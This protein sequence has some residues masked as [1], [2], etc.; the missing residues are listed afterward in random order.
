MKCLKV[1]VCAL[2]VLSCYK[3]ALAG[4]CHEGEGYPRADHI[5]CDD[6]DQYCLGGADW[7]GGPNIWGVPEWYG[8]SSYPSKCPT[9]GSA[10]N[11]HPNYV[12]LRS[13][14]PKFQDCGGDVEAPAQP[15]SG[16]RA[17]TPPMVVHVVN[18]WADGTET[19][20]AQFSHPFTYR[21]QAA[22]PD[23]NALNGTDANPLILRFH[24]DDDAG[25]SVLYSNSYIELSL[26]E[27]STTGARDNRAPTDYVWYTCPGTSH[28]YGPYPIIC[29]QNR[30]W[31]PG[32][33]AICGDLNPG[34]FNS[35]AIGHLPMMDDNPCHEDEVP[36]VNHFPTQDHWVVFD[37][38]QWT[39]IRSNRFHGLTVDPQTD[40]PTPI[41]KRLQC[42]ESAGCNNFLTVGG[43][44]NVH[45]KITTN[46]ILLYITNG[47][48]GSPWGACIPRQYHG[49]FDTIS[50]GVAPGCEL[51]P[52]TGECIGS[53]DCIQYGRPGQ[54]AYR[55]T[56]YDQ[57]S[58]LGGELYFDDSADPVQ[59]CCHTAYDHLLAGQCE[60][61]VSSECEDPGDIWDPVNDFC[62]DI[63][64]CVDPFADADHD[65][66]VDQ[67]DFGI[68]QACFS[69][70]GNDYE[71]GCKCF[72]RDED[73]DVDGDD[74]SRTGDF[75]DFM[76]CW[77]GPTVPAV[78][79]CD[80]GS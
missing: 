70:T 66:D 1:L 30:V 42:N 77:T 47:D 48:A 29:Q 63:V 69:G 58:L 15:L 49:G 17:D 65:G 6:W 50:L 18:K 3:M 80:G 19:A 39:E 61:L 45:V 33:A 43:I 7:H 26:G 20:M 5:W 76:D 44:Q 67:V 57:V 54:V 25:G 79:S 74:F 4:R 56:Y 40:P 60:E 9:D 12:Q 35:I 46:K 55:P 16:G 2:L 51:N 32:I 22:D 75:N 13:Q 37:G 24:F 78:T 52:T 8:G 23:M 36:A 14:W 71:A 38:L 62:D 53:V 27:E 64:C 68:W 72:D 59:A 73:A 41:G 10:V 11:D 31:R 21:I 28:A 34:P